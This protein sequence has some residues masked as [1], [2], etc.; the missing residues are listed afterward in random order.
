V[1][2]DAGDG[3]ALQIACGAFNMAEGDL[4]LNGIDDIREYQRNDMRFLDQ[5]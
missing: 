2:V 4:V 1:D 5:F 3:E